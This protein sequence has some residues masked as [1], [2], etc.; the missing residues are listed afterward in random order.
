MK[1]NQSWF[2]NV[3]NRPHPWPGLNWLTTGIIV[4]DVESAVD[5]YTQAM[6]MVCIFEGENDDGNLFFARIRYRGTNITI[7]K[8]HFDTDILAPS[9]TGQ[10][11]PFIF[12]LY[13]DD[14]KGLFD[15]MTRAGAVVL[16]EPEE[17]FWQDLRARLRDPFGY[18]WDIAQKL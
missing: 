17:T 11:P 9:S 16:M 2:E 10:T 12:Y 14:V 8:E 15:K 5:F 1:R 6:D 18:V 7:Y 13:V 3:D 4:S